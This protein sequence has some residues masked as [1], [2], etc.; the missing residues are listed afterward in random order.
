M[1]NA[2]P[3]NAPSAAPEK[4]RKSAV[5][6]VKDAK[7]VLPTPFDVL[8]PTTRFDDGRI[9]DASL[10]GNDPASPS[11]KA[12]MA[13][14]SPSDFKAPT[15]SEIAED[16]VADGV[17][18]AQRVITLDEALKR[19]SPGALREFYETP[20]ERAVRRSRSP[21]IDRAEASV[22][23][24]KPLRVQVVH[25]HDFAER[26]QATLDRAKEVGQASG[27]REKQEASDRKF[28]RWYQRAG[29]WAAIAFGIVT[30]IGVALDNRDDIAKMLDPSPHPVPPSVQ[31]P[32]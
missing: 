21:I 4:R 8:D 29:F 19:A 1:K 5:Q 24:V 31:A 20:A 13:D 25:E 17:E 27:E 22:P 11:A 28:N 16:A 30:V 23:S 14:L 12:T 18:A 32:R 3:P 2:A 7:P 26:Q 15:A 6:K 9:L 10:L